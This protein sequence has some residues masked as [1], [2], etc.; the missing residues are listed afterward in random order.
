MYVRRPALVPISY[1]HYLCLSAAAAAALGCES[2]DQDQRAAIIE[3][4]VGAAAIVTYRRDDT[5]E[6]QSRDD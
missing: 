6:T 1:F 4:S 5:A 2:G 3:R